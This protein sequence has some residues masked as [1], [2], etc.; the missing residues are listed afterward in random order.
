MRLA[1]RLFARGAMGV[2]LTFFAA[3][4][5][6][7]W[8]FFAAVFSNLLAIIWAADSLS[9]RLGFPRDPGL[10]GCHWSK[11]QNQLPSSETIVP[12]FTRVIP[13]LALTLVYRRKLVGVSRICRYDQ[14]SVDQLE[15]LT[16][17]LQRLEVP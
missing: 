6:N 3:A 7:R 12:S 9:F 2:T 8:A 4:F 17:V 11:A 13:C 15:A 1:T 14:C 16:N 10:K 5:A